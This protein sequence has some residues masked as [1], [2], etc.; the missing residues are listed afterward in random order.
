MRWHAGHLCATAPATGLAPCSSSAGSPD[1][2]SRGVEQFAPHDLECVA[3]GEVYVL[4]VRTRDDDLAARDVDCQ[5]HA[6][7]PP[8]GAAPGI[9]DRHPAGEDVRVVALEVLAQLLDASVQDGRA[10]QVAK[11]DLR[12]LHGVHA[13]R[14][15]A[16]SPQGFR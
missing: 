5:V 9:L 2:Q 11:R 16:P 4:V 6:E 14:W 1:A 3:Q 10:A 13:F 7:L 12:R 15:H 8:L